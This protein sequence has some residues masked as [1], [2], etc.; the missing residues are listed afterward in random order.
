M[1]H[2]YES[3]KTLVQLRNIGVRISIDDFGTGHP[4][5][6]YLRN[7]PLDTLKVDQSFVLDM[8]F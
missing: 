4:N 1:H 3:I 8:A 7:F 2:S 5:L 6:S